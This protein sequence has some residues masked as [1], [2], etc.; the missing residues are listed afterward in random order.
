MVHWNLDILGEMHQWDVQW[1]KRCLL[2]GL[3]DVKWMGCVGRAAHS[4]EVGYTC[5]K[6]TFNSVFQ[7]TVQWLSLNHFCY[8]S[9]LHFFKIIWETNFHL[10]CTQLKFA[11]TQRAQRIEYNMQLC[12]NEEGHSEKI[13]QN[14]GKS[15]L[16]PS[17]LVYP[18]FFVLHVLAYFNLQ[19]KYVIV[20]SSAI[21][22]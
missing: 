12:L 13:C 19:V 8:R 17:M 16:H 15:N 11:N 7:I 20:M 5:N 10:A 4:A 18:W 6:S 22:S 2:S 21:P 1:G 14:L 9:H 3:V